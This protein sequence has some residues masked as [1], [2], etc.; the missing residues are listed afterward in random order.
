M[1]PESERH[2]EKERFVL[3]TKKRFLPLAGLVCLISAGCSTREP[4]VQ[5]ISDGDIE[6]RLKW[7]AMHATIAEGTVILNS[8]AGVEV[9]QI[10]QKLIRLLP[11]TEYRLSV[12]AR[13][14]NTPTA[15]P[16]TEYRLSVKARALNTPTAQL[17]V[18]L[19]LDETYDS[20]EQE[21]VVQPSEIEPIYRTYHRTIDSGTFEEQP[22][23]RI[24]T[25]S[26]VPVEVDEVAIVPVQ[27]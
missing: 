20:P 10:R 17:S 4:G 26:T 22:Y 18:D 1:Q 16:E 23:L 8:P 25:F 19:F 14:L 6:N 9:S 5:Y 27:G 13:A 2:T 7:E 12:K 3:M 11:E 24:F 15:L 21:L